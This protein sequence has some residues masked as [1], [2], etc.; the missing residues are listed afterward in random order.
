MDVQEDG[1]GFLLPA[2][3]A[4]NEDQEDTKP[5]SLEKPIPRKKGHRH[6]HPMK[7][8][9]NKKKH[10]RHRHSYPRMTQQFQVPPPNPLYYAPPSMPPLMP[11]MQAFQALSAMHSM[12]A[13][14]A[15]QPMQPMPM[16]PQPYE[17]YTDTDSSDSD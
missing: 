14:Q 9:H 17:Y 11:P 8:L 16:V 1:E 12:Q 10:K 3:S 2:G 7:Q 4:V 15:M 6:S 13:M 5:P